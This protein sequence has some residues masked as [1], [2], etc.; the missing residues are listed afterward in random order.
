MLNKDEP[1][2]LSCKMCHKKVKVI[3]EAA[4]CTNCNIDNVA[5]EM[6]YRLRL[7]VCGAEQRARVILFETDKYLL[8]CN[9]QEYVQST[10]IKKEECHNYCKLVLSKDK[11]FNFLVRVDLTN[12]NPR[13]LNC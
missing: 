10:S 13:R 4:A 5:Y 7:E 1:W 11:Q 6:R 12:S 8:D 3:E 9:V 2:Y